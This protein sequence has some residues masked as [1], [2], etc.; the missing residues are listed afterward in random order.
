MHHL[1]SFILRIAYAG[2]FGFILLWHTEDI[3]KYIPQL[4]GGLLMLECIAQLLELFVL[5]TK[6]RVHG[7]FFIV[8]GVIMA[9]SLF[10]IFFCQ[11]P[12][13]LNN[14]LTQFSTLIKLKIELKLGG[15]CFIAFLISEIVIS[16]RFFKPLYRPKQFAEERAKKLEAEKALEAERARQAE[17]E[18][19]RIEAEREKLEAE[20]LCKDSEVAQNTNSECIST[21]TEEQ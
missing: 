21:K 20:A 12:I 9:Y 18:R 11:M 8:P 19:K 7:G 17:A 13:D 10:L 14:F 1:I 15:A 2:A 5:K 4:L 3:I 6:T 16:A